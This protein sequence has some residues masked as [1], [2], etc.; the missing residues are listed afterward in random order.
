[1]PVAPLFFFAVE[2]AGNRVTPK[3]KPPGAFSSFVGG[4]L[5]DVH[6]FGVREELTPPETFPGL[7]KVVGVIALRA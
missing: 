5:L 3:G 6:V 1:V 7:L 2:A 4:A